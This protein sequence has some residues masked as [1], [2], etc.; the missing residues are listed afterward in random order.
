MTTL[1]KS[2]LRTLAVAALLAGT[3]FSQTTA[4]AAGDAPDAR[5][6]FAAILARLEANPKPTPAEYGALH[7][8]L[9][10]A[11]E[12]AE[13]IPGLLRAGKVGPDASAHL[14]YA[15]EDIG[16][17]E[18]QTALAS[19]H[20]DPAQRHVD[21][22]RAAISLGSVTAPTSSSLASL[23]A[24]VERR[25]DPDSVDLANTSLL[26]LGSAGH[27]LAASGSAEYVG[28][29]DEL[30]H[31]MRTTPHGTER[32]MVLK[33]LG[34]LGDRALAGEISNHLV[35]GSAPVR[36]SAAE[37]L[38]RLGD[39]GQREVLVALLP[40]E[41]HGA[42]RAHMV[43]ALRG[44]PADRAALGLVHVMIQSE[45]HTHSRAQMV[46]YLVEHLRDYRD[47]I[48]TLRQMVSSDPSN[49]V[50]LLASS[51]LSL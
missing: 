43:E 40:N 46:R 6:R 28:V 21:R 20:A 31:R 32:V 42:V 50:R 24:A 25:S 29:R 14:I 48:E 34:N 22:L 36:A 45:E 26:A 38:G 12:L 9:A 1:T 10:K 7:D 44:M 33:A 5:T 18:T 23:R 15:L 8:L 3:A 11:P 51:V 49:E 47:S 13:E 35:D 4:R 37:T 39:E 30:L 27:W 2:G 41:P 17:P 19:I 16:T